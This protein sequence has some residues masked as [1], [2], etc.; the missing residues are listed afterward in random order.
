MIADIGTRKGAKL[1]N[2]SENSVWIKGLD[3][4]HKDKSEFPVSTVNEIKLCTSEKSIYNEEILKNDYTDLSFSNQDTCN[5]A[6][7]KNMSKHLEERYKFCNYL[8]DPNRFRLKKVINVLALVFLYISNL[9]FIVKQKNLATASISE[10]PVVSS[11]N[12]KK[13]EKYLVTEGRR[14]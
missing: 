10:I 3:W 1:E 9:R 11:Q 8:I 2:V 6:K 14:H 7:S 13:T 12:E 5:F 4:M